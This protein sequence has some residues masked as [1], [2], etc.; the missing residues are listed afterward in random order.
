MITVN[1]KNSAINVT[2]S[3]FVFMLLPLLVLLASFTKENKVYNRLTAGRSD[4]LVWAAN[5][6]FKTVKTISAYL[7]LVQDKNDII[8]PF[9]VNFLP[10]DPD[11]TTPS[12][13]SVTRASGSARARTQ[14]K[15]YL[16]SL[17]IDPKSPGLLK[18][19]KQ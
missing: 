10:A 2:K 6:K 4:T 13:I 1:K 11:E 5:A 3:T 19:A 12:S 7:E 18:N 17:A 9:P 8:R 14:L 16:D 15:A